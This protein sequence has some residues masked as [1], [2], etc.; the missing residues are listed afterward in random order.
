[1]EA[2]VAVMRQER[3]LVCPGEC[4]DIH[5]IITGVDDRPAVDVRIRK[6]QPRHRESE[7]P[8]SDADWRTIRGYRVPP[9]A[10][11]LFRKL[12]EKRDSWLS[13]EEIGPSKAVADNLNSVLGKLKSPFRLMRVKEVEP[14]CNGCRR[15]RR[16]ETDRFRLV[17]VQVA[18]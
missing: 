2:L 3:T 14:V 17:R 16:W 8:I 9:W 18:V 10:Q 6:K 15:S 4:A 13:G 11:E 7:E 5:V 12:Y 1:M